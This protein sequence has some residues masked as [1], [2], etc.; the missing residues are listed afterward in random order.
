MAPALVNYLADLEAQ[1]PGWRLARRPIMAEL[2]DGLHDATAHYQ[3]RGLDPAAA[4]A[5]AVQDCGPASVVA[6]DVAELLAT[7]QARRT[8]LTLLLTGPFIGALWLLTLVPGQAPDALLVR[9]P[10]LGQLVLATLVAGL[11]TLIA[12]GPVSHRLP[13]LRLAPCRAVAAACAAAAVCDIVV[14]ATATLAALEQPSTTR[15]MPGLI[16][17]SASLLRLTLAQR[18]ARRD[19]LPSPFA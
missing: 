15:W 12:T 14:L 4:A 17:V 10:A 6:A 7:G 8:A 18:V 3:T 9:I 2:A 16:A 19:L 11:L 13:N 1:I 5:R